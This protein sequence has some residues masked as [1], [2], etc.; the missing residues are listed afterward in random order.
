AGPVAVYFRG[1]FQDSPAMPSESQQT[2]AA[3]AAADFTPTRLAHGTTATNQFALLDGM[4]SV[5]INNVQISVG[6]QSAWLGP[7]E[8]GSLLMSNNAAP[9]PMVKIDDVLPHKIPGLSR[10]L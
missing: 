1:E 4:A 2:L 5:N 8:S 7:G 9:F 10:I 6:K 3:T